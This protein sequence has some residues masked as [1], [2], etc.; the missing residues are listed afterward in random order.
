[1]GTNPNP[2]AG[3]KQDN[4]PQSPD[5]YEKG[6]ELAEACKHQEA[7]AYM[8]ESL[9]AAPHDAQV[10][11]DTGAILY[12]LGRSDEAV[13]HFVKARSLQ[14]DNAEIV[15][16]LAEAYLAV[17]RANE[18]MQLFDQMD[19]MGV[20]NVDILNRAAAIF[21]D[22]DKKGDAIEMLLRSLRIWPDQEMLHPMLKVVRSKRPKVAFFC[23]DDGTKLSDEIAEF[24]K[25]RF[26]MYIFDGQ[27]EE[28]IYELMKWSDIS[29]F[30]SCTNLAARGL[31]QPKVCKNIVAVRRCNGPEQ[32]LE[33][34]DWGNIDIFA[35]IGSSLVK[36]ALV[37]GVSELESQ[38]SIAVIPN[39]V[40]L[41]KF[42]F[43]N[44]QH[45]KN[46]AFSSDLGAAK[47]LAFILEC[48]QKLHHIDPE[49][50]LF[51][52]REFEDKAFEE[53]I[54]CGKNAALVVGVAISVYFFHH[55]FFSRSR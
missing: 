38:P 36:D 50:R 48:M 51:F 33:Q 1:M 46:I 28:E 23:G 39:G 45:G 3:Q 31:K 17:G 27:A 30:E 2:P 13:D 29:W 37:N 44:R 6:L 55:A 53:Y 4:V 49:Y 26:E 35:A 47:N 34:V 5:H 54:Q 25:P 20:L 7:L 43:T 14:N 40:N 21:L 52:G 10:L 9:R 8:Q 16:N 18:A 12:C 22:Q 19:R 24:V 42:A 41:E 32:W 11:N 15:W